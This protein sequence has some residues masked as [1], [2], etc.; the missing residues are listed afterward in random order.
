MASK[1][2]CLKF[3]ILPRNKKVYLLGFKLLIANMYVL[4]S[5]HA[6]EETTLEIGGIYK[7]HNALIVFV[8]D[9]NIKCVIQNPVNALSIE[10]YVLRF[11]MTRTIIHCND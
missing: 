10:K 3:G 9:K 4:N 1:I 8:S 6:K 11:S 2:Y 7:W 5:V